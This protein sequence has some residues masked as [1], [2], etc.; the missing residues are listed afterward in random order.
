MFVFGSVS[1]LYRCS[2]P[3][4]GEVNRSPNFSANCSANQASAP[5]P[6]SRFFCNATATPFRQAVAPSPEMFG[7]CFKTM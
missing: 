6:G 3:T 7:S 4:G 1:F 2:C 5:A